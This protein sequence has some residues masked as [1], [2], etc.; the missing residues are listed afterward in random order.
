[1]TAASP[2][3]A[4]RF[5]VLV[6]PLLDDAYSLAKWLCRDANDAE[7]IV[8][9]AA[10]RA[11]KALETTSV[12]RPKPWFLAIVRNAAVTWMARNRRK[13]LAF[14]G[15]LD[16]LDALAPGDGNAAADPEALLI[17]VQDGERLRRA[18]AALPPPL[19]EILILRDVN[20]LSY[21]DIAEAAGLPMGTV[22]SRLAR[23]RGALARSLKAD[24]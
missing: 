19:L 4:E 10:V 16:D 17:A 11:L 22:M 12:D 18:M 21:R 3:A 2:H 15:G 13:D 14:A 24:P 6:P 20:G 1:M 5:R 8:Q 9:E 7:D 23:A